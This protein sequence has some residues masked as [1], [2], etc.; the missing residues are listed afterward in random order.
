MIEIGEMS[1]RVPNMNVEDAQA[2]GAAIAE[3]LAARLP[4]DVNDKQVDELN[5]KI[6]L[7]PGMAREAMTNNITDQILQ[8]LRM[9]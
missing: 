2:M 5:I 6:S 1:I 8:Q 7:S 9:L 3:Q 4:E